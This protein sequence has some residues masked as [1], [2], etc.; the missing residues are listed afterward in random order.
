MLNLILLLQF[1][2]F[3]ALCFGGGYMI[4]PMLM[5]TFVVHERFFSLDQFGNL[6]SV[7]QMTPGAV[8]VNTA[9]YVGFL[10]NGISGALAA[11]AGLVL[12]TLFLSVLA[13][14]FL[15]RWKETRVVQGAL[16]GAR[17]AAFAMI[18]GAVLI[19]MGMSVF[20]EPIPFRQ[21][22]LFLMG[23]DPVFPDLVINPLETVVCLVCAVLVYK[24]RISIT[25][26][27]FAA[28]FLGAL[29]GSVV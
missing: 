8:S 11:T 13:I 14:S 25:A 19:F 18:C 29:M 24:T 3:G 22:C 9:V 21:M 12:P 27:L 7:S 28:A 4:I 10:K 26:L 17:V 2:K 23:Q 6:L 16:K 20:S 1:A 15:N 5:D